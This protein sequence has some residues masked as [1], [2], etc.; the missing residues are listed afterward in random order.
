MALDP[1]SGSIQ[2]ATSTAPPFPPGAAA[3]RTGLGAALAVLA[4]AN[5]FG[6]LLA[7]AVAP[8][9][10]ARPAFG[11]V[12]WSFVLGAGLLIGAIA[13]TGLYVLLANAS[14]SRAETGA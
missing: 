12:P 6:F 13:V 14:E 1:G 11:R 9:A 4:A 3:Q 10:L 5:Y 8:Q 2:V 7:A